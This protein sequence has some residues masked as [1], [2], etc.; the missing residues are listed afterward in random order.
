MKSVFVALVLAATILYP[1]ICEAQCKPCNGSGQSV[2]SSCG[3]RTY[4]VTHDKFGVPG[5]YGCTAC[6][7]TR[8]EPFNRFDPQY[9]KGQ[10]GTGKVRCNACEGTGLNAAQREELRRKEE[11]RRIREAEAQVAIKTFDNLCSEGRWQEADSAFIDLQTK[12]GDTEALK[13]AAKKIRDRQ[14][15]RA[16]LENSQLAAERILSE[17]VARQKREAQM[18]EGLARAQKMLGELSK[19]L[20]EPKSLES[21]GLE[22]FDGKGGTTNQEGTKTLFDRGTKDSAPPDARVKGPSKLDVGDGVKIPVAPATIPPP[23]D[24]EFI[25]PKKD[26]GLRAPEAKDLDL[27]FQ[28]HLGPGEK[29]RTVLFPSNP[30]PL[31]NVLTDPKLMKEIEEKYGVKEPAYKDLVDK[32]LKGGFDKFWEDSWFIDSLKL[33]GKVPAGADE[34]KYIEAKDRIV[35]QKDLKKSAS[36]KQAF[37]EVSLEFATLIDEGHLR[38]GET[39]SER[40]RVDPKLAG[41]QNGILVRAKFRHE[42]RCKVIRDAANNELNAVVDRLKKE[43]EQK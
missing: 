3:G 32:V 20:S 33:E 21:G 14:E 28:A 43:A 18:N 31:K 25:N 36:L 8:G 40:A 5:H 35:N 12:Y 22:F 10:Y 6:G 9:G 19:S 27:L 39:L 13:N 16:A 23:Q 17:Q 41:L 24:L 11:Q 4:T 34:S 38:K 30:E 2:C 37:E 15:L 29:A 1:S 42:A 26:T 7:G